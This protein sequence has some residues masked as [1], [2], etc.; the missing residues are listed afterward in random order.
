M[1]DMIFAW[2]QA[3]VPAPLSYFKSPAIKEG[4]TRGSA[5]TGDAYDY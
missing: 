5:P 1:N 4:R 2:E 3:S